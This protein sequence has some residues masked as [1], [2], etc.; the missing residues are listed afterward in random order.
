MVRQKIKTQSIVPRIDG[1][2]RD[3]EKL[4]KLGELPLSRFADEDS[5][6]KA[7]FYLRRALE[8]VFHVGAHLLT[9]LPGGRAA[10]YKTIALK[11]GET[12]IVPKSFAEKKLK[13]MAGYRNQL[14]HFYADVKPE[15]IYRIIKEDLRDFNTFL[16]AIRRVLNNPEKFNLSVE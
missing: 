15:E 6:I 9:R 1:V 12:G 11:L 4:Q 3:V 2:E 5:F 7:Q 14:T 16:E 8:A 10:E 13:A